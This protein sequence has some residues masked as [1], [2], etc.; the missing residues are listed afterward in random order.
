MRGFNSTGGFDGSNM[1][2]S[3]A[4]ELL[5]S[6]TLRENEEAMCEMLET[7]ANPSPPPQSWRKYGEVCCF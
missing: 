6:Q 7:L 3:T 5:P 4:V 2:L 1:L